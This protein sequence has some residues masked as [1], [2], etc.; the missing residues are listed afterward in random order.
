MEQSDVLFRLA[1]ALAIGLLIGV[2]RGWKQRESRSK[3]RVAGFRT[4][5]LIGLLGGV[6]GLLG[7]RLGA[8]AFVALAVGFAIPWFVFKLWDIVVDAD[9]S[10]TG[11]VAGLLVFALG[12]LAATGA[13]EPALAASVALAGIL[14]FKK[15]MHGW[16]NMLRWDELRAAFLILAASLVALPLLPDQAFGPF[17]AVNPRELWVLTIALA[18][19]S[20]SGHVAVR[21]LG[22][23]RG[24]MAAGLAGAL[25][26]ST[27]VTLDMARRSRAGAAAATLAAAVAAGANAVMFARIVILL[28]V[29]GRPA[30]ALAGPPL[31][32][33]ALVS[34]VFAAVFWIRSGSPAAAGAPASETRPVDL[35]FVAQVAAMLALITAVTRITSGVW[36]EAAVTPTAMIAGL[37]DV[38]AVTLAIA[39]LARDGLAAPIAAT[40]ALAAAGAAAVSKATLGAGFGSPGFAWRHLVS[41]GASLAAGGAVLAVPRF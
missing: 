26:S 2:E 12:A 39:G 29:F 37:A 3:A 24:L 18:G 27:A 6:A 19:L 32:A 20:F 28:A 7:E 36:G 40:A 4:F 13:V 14:A 30:F 15:A 31:A 25:V 1:A 16:L 35:V 11:L 23:R 21:L 5:A 8:G 22:P 9:P 41:T 17:S 38:D 10:I 34:G 33:A